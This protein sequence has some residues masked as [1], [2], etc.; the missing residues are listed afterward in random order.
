MISIEVF[1]D[2]S[3]DFIGWTVLYFFIWWYS[4]GFKKTLLFSWQKIK[5]GWRNLA[6]SILFA[7]FFKP[8]YGQ[9]GF[10]AFVLSI[11]VHFWQ[12]SWRLCLMILW[13][14]VWLLVP[15]VWVFL[16]IFSLWQ[17]FLLIVL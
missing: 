11:G 15:L 5:N 7:N 10:A 14:I 4:R 1:K 12:L 3:S 6:L 2:L 17:L 13:F 9:R 8:M 16:P